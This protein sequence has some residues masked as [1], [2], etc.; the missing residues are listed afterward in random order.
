M[1][2]IHCHSLES[3]GVRLAHQTKANIRHSYAEES[4]NVCL[5]Y[6]AIAVVSQSCISALRSL[7]HLIVDSKNSTT[8]I[9]DEKKLVYSRPRHINVWSLCNIARIKGRKDLP[10]LFS[11]TTSHWVGSSVDKFVELRLPS[12]S[13]L[14]LPILFAAAAAEIFSF[15]VQGLPLLCNSSSIDIFSSWWLLPV[16]LLKKTSIAAGVFH[17]LIHENVEYR[18]EIPSKEEK[19]WSSSLINL[20]VDNI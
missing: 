19:S 11:R 18:E 8:N 6:L 10:I 1:I 15:H 5:I 4:Y 2:Y 3:S 16:V 13:V 17:Q 7:K 12:L 20:A 14:P 9:Q